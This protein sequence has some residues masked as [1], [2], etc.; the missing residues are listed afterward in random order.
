MCVASSARLCVGGTSAR[1]RTQ[2]KLPA[3][4]PGKAGS[5]QVREREQPSQEVLAPKRDDG[6]D[7]AWHEQP[8]NVGQER[9]RSVLHERTVQCALV[10]HQLEAAIAE[11]LT[12]IAYV[13]L[14]P[15]YTGI[16]IL[17]SHVLHA[18]QLAVRSSHAL[19]AVSCEP[20]SEVRSPTADVDRT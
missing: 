2:Q 16:A 18:A 20:D 15:V 14:D 3:S 5:G 1:L 8:R 7:T 13:A 9:S 11:L 4:P 17:H 12:V 10:N 6:I 19:V